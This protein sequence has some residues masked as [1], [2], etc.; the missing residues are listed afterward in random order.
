ME[1]MRKVGRAVWMEVDLDAMTH[2]VKQLKK[3][4]KNPS[5]GN[6]HTILQFFSLYS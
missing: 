6:G 2:N 4:S 5:V 3:L 1:V